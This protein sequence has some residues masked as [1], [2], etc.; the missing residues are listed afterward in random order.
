MLLEIQCK[1][2]GVPLMWKGMSHNHEI[3]CQKFNYICSQ[4]SS[5]Q[6]FRQMPCYI[7]MERL[8]FECP[9][10]QIAFHVYILW[11]TGETRWKWGEKGKIV[12]S[13]VNIVTQ[14]IIWNKEETER[15]EP[16]GM[17][18]WNGRYFD[19]YVIGSKA[20]TGPVTP[21]GKSN[22]S[23]FIYIMSGMPMNLSHILDFMIV[24]LSWILN[25]QGF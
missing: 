12:H 6:F 21:E 22:D 23:F 16:D 9:P 11:W 8:V 1:H 2:P 4:N 20:V 3:L 19:L 18:R 5:S 10:S 17:Q 7:T 14:K 15:Q 25:L 13:T 24:S